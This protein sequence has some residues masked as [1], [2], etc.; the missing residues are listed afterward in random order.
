[1]R[2]RNP[3]RRRL[4]EHLRFETDVQRDVVNIY[5]S[6]GCTVYATSNRRRTEATPGHPDLVVFQPNR[7][8]MW[9]HETKTQ[10]GRL[11]KEQKQFIGRAAECGVQ[12]VVGGTQ[13][14]R[15]FLTAQIVR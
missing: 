2:A 13:A 9:W 5:Q 11:S 12:V 7:C 14:A 8:R 10:D 6:C 4:P 15:D 1:M 3:R